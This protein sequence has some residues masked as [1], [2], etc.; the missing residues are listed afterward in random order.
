ME[1]RVWL[2]MI[3]VWHIV[4]LSIWTSQNIIIFV[5]GSS[6]VDNLVDRVKLFSWK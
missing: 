3:L 1:H 6:K 5:G 4:V 2:G